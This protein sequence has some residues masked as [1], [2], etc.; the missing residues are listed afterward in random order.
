VGLILNLSLRN[1][2]RQKRRN[3]LLGI[4]ISFG[5][6]I[7]VIA[8]SFS[9]GMVDVLIKDVVSY[10]YGHLAIDGM[11]G[12]SQMT[13][14][15]RDKQRVLNIINDT[16]PKEELIGLDE[17]IGTLARAIGNGEADNIFVVGA[18]VKS[19]KDKKDFFEGFFTLVDGN[20]E[21]YFS[22][23]IEY[24]VIISAAVAKSLNVKVRDVIKARFPMVTGQV[25]T[26]Q[27]TVIAIANGNNT[28]M[29][30]VVFLDGERAKRLFGYKTWESASLQMTLKNPQQTAKIYADILHRKLQ[31]E[32]LS[33]AGKAGREE[34][35]IFAFKNDA[36]SKEKLSRNI[37]IIAGDPQKAFEKEGVM[38]SN[39]LAR[40]LNLRVG[41][42]FTYE[43]QTK[44]RGPYREKFKIDA[45]Y[46]SATK[47]GGNI[48]LMNGER[49]YETY[50]RFLP[51][52]RTP[53][54]IEKNNPLY[55]VL[56]TEWKL[57][58]RTRDGVELQKMLKEDRKIRT[59]QSKLN[60]STMY[61]VASQLLQF[62]GVLNSITLIAVLL[63]FFI[64]LIGVIN[65]LRMTVKERTREIGTIRAIGMQKK[66]VRNMFITETLLLSAISCA[67]GIVLGIVVMRILGS[68]TFGTGSDLSMILKDR[69]IYFKMDPVG[70]SMNF[71]LIM[72][73][74]GGTAYFPARRAARLS[75]VEALRHYE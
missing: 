15:I 61:E 74:S 51:A 37:N 20:F 33:I 26:A 47:L 8:N 9:H 42:E 68:I 28:F 66:D 46:N 53:G 13:T 67:A 21:D 12:N 19:E 63:L 73:I 11:Q 5:M 2:L 40:K 18:S 7:L 50:D 55:P 6:M 35:Q 17:K 60:V 71:L 32:L 45:I 39:Q 48:I 27:F 25:E 64:I 69:H 57:F 41:N 14:M 1:L 16:I 70:I 58:D 56:A 34:C 10:V 62:E 36:V 23:D 59:T 44:F 31:P 52:N 43:Y 24:P 3:L 38:V 75:A 54:Y 22:K 49:I 30:I 65:T 29:N 4:G 72:L